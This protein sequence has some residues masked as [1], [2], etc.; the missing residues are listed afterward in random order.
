MLKVKCLPMKISM[1]ELSMSSWPCEGFKC[2][3]TTT[4]MC[5]N[6]PFWKTTVSGEIFKILWKSLKKCTKTQN[7]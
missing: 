6:I 2:L 1:M 5:S 7:L 4:G 3:S